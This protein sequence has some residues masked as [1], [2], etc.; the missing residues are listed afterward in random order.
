MKADRI[1]LL[2]LLISNTLVFGTHKANAQVQQ[3][4][5]TE[6]LGATNNNERVVILEPNTSL[7]IKNKF[8]DRGI[9]TRKMLRVLGKVLVPEPFADR[10][11]TLFRESEF[12]IDDHLNT[13]LVK[14]DKYSLYFEGNNNN[15]EQCAYYRV[16]NEDACL[17]QFDIECNI[18]SDNLT[19]STNGDFGLTL[20]VYYAAN[21]R[22][23]G[24]VYEKPDTTVYFD[25]AD[26]TYGFTK[27]K[28][29]VSLPEK[30]L[31]IL[32][33]VGG[34]HFSGNCHIEAPKFRYNN[35]LIKD[36]AFEPFAE[37]QDSINYWVGVNLSSRSWPKW[38]LDYNGEIIFEGNLFDRASN[39]A[40]FYIFLPTDLEAEGV[41]NL[42]LQREPYKAAFPYQIK[43][44]ELIEETARDVEIAY[45]PK[46]VFVGDTF[47]IMLEI[48]KPNVDVEIVSHNIALQATKS[49]CRFE[50]PGLEV[51]HLVADDLAVNAKFTVKTGATTLEGVVSQTIQTTGNRVYISSGDEVYVDMVPG[52]YDY[53]FKWYL[54]NRV[55]NWYQFRPSYQWSGFRVAEDK[56]ISRYVDLL[57]KLNIPYAWQ[58]EG[59]TLAGK[60]INPAL[61]ALESPMFKGKQAHENDG[62]YYYWD[63]FKY[64]GLWTDI[65]A[66]YYPL[67]GVF[68]KHKPIYTAN[69]RFVHYDPHS[70]KDMAEGAAQFVSNLAGSR[71]ES[72]RHT[73]PSSLFRYFF[74]AGY[75]WV[76]A[77]Q[78]YGPEEIILSALRGASR[79]YQKE[80]YGSLH[81]VQ[82]GSF[83]FTRP[84]HALRLYMS[85]TLAYMH[86][87]NHIN[88]EEGLWTDEYLNDRYSKSGKQHLYAQNYILDYVQTHSRRGEQYVPIAMIQGRNCSWKSSG[89]TN[90]WAQTADKWKFNRAQESFDLLKIFYPNSEVNWCGPNNWFS[91][92]PYGA[93]DLLPIEAPE[94]VLNKY[95][96]L[97][98]VGW[99]SYDQSDFNRLEQ[100]VSEGGTL[101]MSAAHIN[102][103]LQPDLET[104][105]PVD[106]KVIK[107]M[108]GVDYRSYSS[109]RVIKL[110]KGRIIYYPQN[111]YPIEDAI[112]EDY[113]KDIRSEAESIITREKKRAWIT[114]NE[115]VG[116]TVWDDGNRRT[117]YIL[118]TDWKAKDVNQ[119]ATLHVGG[120]TFD[121]DVHQHKLETLTIEND[122]FVYPEGNT[123]DVLDISRK[124]KYW[125][126]KVQ[127]TSADVV[128][129]SDIRTGNEYTYDIDAVGICTISSDSVRRE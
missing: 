110:G 91:P 55:G 5:R 118:H 60:N 51:I 46:Y 80:E 71:G 97:V 7:S 27:K 127:T 63:H 84:E 81:A 61:S 85:L 16:T 47:G 68:A 13:E 113:E 124:G 89:R 114:S 12:I 36:M 58:V 28:C 108:L 59:R 111:V 29:T 14:S 112:R 25:I 120:K 53:F 92:T 44:I 119:K 9:E 88:T 24:E 66:R 79:A 64:E 99:N 123:T 75:E 18:K 39:V 20:E 82:W 96:C 87:V 129:I 33:K 90:V 121:V 105:F 50:T 100:F 2:I 107:C 101:I 116:F 128:R 32:V 42:S 122:L 95:K 8:L 35:K 109:R 34:I 74:Q 43:S 3:E 115:N 83:P 19:K 77:E 62:G 67:G 11:E 26:G 102:S 65:R 45:V 21:G 70:V 103:V 93:I 15:Y 23:E 38:K 49:K 4:F 98:F 40:D 22:F 78:M 48:N 57:N 126:I 10:G 69:G 41:F 1:L 54:R 6:L 30:P 73:G 94:N 56:E 117:I 106:D 31:T 17:R 37:R 86:G 52:L 104:K 72:T 125:E 76:G